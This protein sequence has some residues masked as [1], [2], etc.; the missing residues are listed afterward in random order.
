MR[1]GVWLPKKISTPKGRFHIKEEDVRVKDGQVQLYNF[2]DVLSFLKGE[3]LFG[4]QVFRT[5][6]IV[7]DQMIN[8]Y[9]K[10]GVVI[11]YCPNY[12]YLEVFGLFD[13]D[14]QVLYDEHEKNY[15]RLI[16]KLDEAGADKEL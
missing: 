2:E 6:N 14:F 15:Q 3:Q 13:D 16:H 11:D 10:D 7:G 8:I 12:E 5:R 1:S 4:M 9:R